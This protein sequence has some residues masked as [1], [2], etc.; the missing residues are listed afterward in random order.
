[1]IAHA[2]YSTSN[3]QYNQPIVG[4]S[5]AVVHN[6]VITQ[7]DPQMWESQY[8]YKCETQNDSELI[9]R[10]VENGDNPLNK[11]PTSSIAALT[12]DGRGHLTYMR[13]SQRPLWMGK[14]GEGIVYA[15]TYDILHR[16]GV[17]E[18]SPVV[19]S[20][21]KDLQRRNYLQWQTHKQKL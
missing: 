6:G 20:E 2:R 15:S 17:A 7:S 4:K 5:L 11:F 8:G 12:L 9:L 10:A 13:N 14:I 1:M 16:A 18:I 21:H 19:S 3:I